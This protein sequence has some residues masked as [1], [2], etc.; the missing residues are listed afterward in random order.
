[1]P[2]YVT[3]IDEAGRGCVIGPLVM[4]GVKIEERHSSALLERGVT[5]SKKL[6]PRKRNDLAKFIEDTARDLCVIPCPPQE[7]DLFCAQKRLNVLEAEKACLI[8]RKLHA[9]EVYVDAPGKGGH[10]F[11][12]QMT[13]LLE[14]HSVEIIAENHADLNYPV[15]SAASILAKVHRD[16]S[17]AELRD[18][19]GDFGSGYPSDPKTRKFLAQVLA[20]GDI[21]PYVRSTWQTV[22]KLRGKLRQERWF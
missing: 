15:V 19:V 14:D 13:Q 4:A 8:I 18:K 16:R 21:P 5:D 7:V 1:M 17:I 9:R 3:G 11:R 20:D 6:S 10:K 12:A 22:R 2:K